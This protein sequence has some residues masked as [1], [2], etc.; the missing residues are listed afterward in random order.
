MLEGPG[1]E[2]EAMAISPEQAG[3]LLDGFKLG[4][5]ARLPIAQGNE[6]KP[7]DRKGRNW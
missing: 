1:R 5:D 2:G 3:Q 7:K 6:S 4:G